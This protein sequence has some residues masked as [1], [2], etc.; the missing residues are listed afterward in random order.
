[1]RQDAAEK[2]SPDD[3]EMPP[4]ATAPVTIAS[5]APGE[6]ESRMRAVDWSHTP[7]G[8]L[9]SWPIEIRS[10]ISVCLSELERAG[11]RPLS[12]RKRR[13]TRTSEAPAPTALDPVHESLRAVLDV[14]PEG[15][16]ITNTAGWFTLANRAAVSL[17]GIDATN[18]PLPR[19]NDE[20][21]TRLN[22]R[23]DDGTPYPAGELPMW[24]SLLLG[25]DVHGNQ[26]Q[27]RNLS[28]GRD[29]P[30]LLNCAPLRDPSGTIRGAVAVFQDISPLK[31]L[32][33]QK[34]EFLTTISH[35]L[36]NPIT[37]ISGMAQMMQQRIERMQGQDA[38]RLRRGLETIRGSATQMTRML[39][40]L[41]DITRL[42]MAR[43]LTLEL[44]P[45]D[46]VAL[47]ER[48]VKVYWQT[49]EQHAVRLH[50]AQPSIVVLCDAGRFER[51]IDNLLSNAIKFSPH[52]GPVTVNLST[53][54]SDEPSRPGTVW[55]VLT[56]RDEGIGIPDEALP[57]I[58]EQFY[59]ATNVVGRIAGSGIG[60]VGA[61]RIVE[62][63]GGT[64]GIASKQ[65]AGTTVTL[66]LPLSGPYASPPA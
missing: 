44:G 45:V 16:L 54:V 1:M 3:S 40:E 2:P 58:F 66:R 46:L 34:D 48:L 49:T 52:G 57:H 39:T 4:R 65:G 30:I 26:L 32:D 11:T 33:H 6:L 18:R 37:A 8:P 14:L 63:H 28:T 36:K 19:E 12:R 24:R 41:V 55:A 5:L 31:D 47:T 62:Q 15:V 27:I 22:V 51:V 21:Y 43:P 64:I 42:Q 29:L 35:D 38:A 59:R 17:L 13:S 50:A 10:A 20:I 7:L 9:D 23:R 53:T 60:L 61:R 25:E 56:V